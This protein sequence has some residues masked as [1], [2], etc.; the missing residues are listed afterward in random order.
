MRFSK[1][2]AVEADVVEIDG[3]VAAGI[4]TAIAAQFEAE[5]RTDA[6]AGGIEAPFDGSVELLDV[7]QPEADAPDHLAIPVIRLQDEGIVIPLPLAHLSAEQHARVPLV[8]IFEVLRVGAAGDDDELLD[9]GRFILAPGLRDDAQR[10]DRAAGVDAL[11]LVHLALFLGLENLEVNHLMRGRVIILAQLH[12]ETDARH[13]IVANDHPP[14]LTTR[15]RFIMGPE[16]VHDLVFRRALGAGVKR[17][18][19]ATGRRMTG[20]RNELRPLRRAR[21]LVDGGAKFLIGAR[22]EDG[23]RTF[24]FHGLLLVEIE[25]QALLGLGGS[26]CSGQQACCYNTDARKQ[27]VQNVHPY[28]I[29]SDNGAQGCLL[30]KDPIQAAANFATT[31]SRSPILYRENDRAPEICSIATP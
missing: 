6:I 27:R 16:A 9:A 28:A 29:P 2:S 18:A 4:G 11:D 25:R 17:D 7:V 3:L 14:L 1:P 23:G 24:G 31:S 13:P 19:Q 20:L 22:V 10:Q 5:L 30:R 8:I 12:G 21:A 26:V 15:Q